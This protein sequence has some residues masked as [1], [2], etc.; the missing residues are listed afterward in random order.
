MNWCLNTEASVARVVR[1]HPCVYIYSWVNNLWSHLSNILTLQV[2]N[3]PMSWID[4]E[5]VRYRFSHARIT[6]ANCDVNTSVAQ[7]IVT[8]SPKREQTEWGTI[9][10]GENG[11]SVVMYGFIMSCKKYSNVGAFVTNC[12]YADARVIFVFIS[13]LDSQL[14][15]WTRKWPYHERINTSPR[16]PI[17]YLRFIIR[18]ENSK[19]AITKCGNPFPE[20]FADLHTI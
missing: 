16:K 4:I 13:L 18:L 2:M 8:S 11:F 7:S 12:L 19:Y 20:H 9:S 14:M 1:T 3:I 10:M 15:K 6:T 17:C 5:R